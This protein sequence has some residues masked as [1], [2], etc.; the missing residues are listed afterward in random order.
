MKSF[1]FVFLGSGVG[2]V[3]RYG[4]SLAFAPATNLKFPW[5]TLLANMAAAFLVGLFYA[6]LSQRT[7]MDKNYFLLLTVGLCGGLSTFSTFSFET[8]KLWQSQQY[9]ISILYVLLSMISCILFTFIGTK[10]VQ[11]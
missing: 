10:V 2:G 5:A 7:W 8:L 4:I 6:I 3:L 9:M 1:F 11:G